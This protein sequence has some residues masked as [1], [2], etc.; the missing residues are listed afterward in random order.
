MQLGY[1]DIRPKNTIKP[2]NNLNLCRASSFFTFKTLPPHRDSPRDY[3]FLL[4]PNRWLPP[5]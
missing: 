3:H 4:P 2:S 5:P 1:R